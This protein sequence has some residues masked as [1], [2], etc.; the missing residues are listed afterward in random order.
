MQHLK[1]K[2]AKGFRVRIGNK[3]RRSIALRDIGSGVAR[4]NEHRYKLSKGILMFIERGDEP[5][6]YK[7]NGEP[8]PLLCGQC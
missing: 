6:A 3:R 8:L 5:P 7:S 2:F 1:L 4:V